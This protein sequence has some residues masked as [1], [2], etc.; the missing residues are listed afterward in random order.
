[1][2]PSWLFSRCGSRMC[3]NL[4]K[5]FLG[6]ADNNLIGKI[7]RVSR[8]QCNVYISQR[9]RRLQKIYLLYQQAYNDYA[10]LLFLY[11]VLR[12]IGLSRQA[13]LLG[14]CGFRWMDHGISEEEM[15]CQAD[16][17][18][19]VQNAVSST[20][21]NDV[22]VLPEYWEN[23]LD[24]AEVKM[25]KYPSREAGGLMEYK[26]YG[27]FSD[28]SAK[29]FFNIQMDNEYRKKWDEL[30]VKIEVVEED[31]KRKEQVLQ[32]VT[33]LPYPFAP[34]EYLCTRRTM[35][36]EDTK[37]VVISARA[38]S[39]AKCPPCKGYVRV[40]SY[41]SHMVFRPHKNYDEA[42]FDYLL[43]YC[44]D[45]QIVLPNRLASWVISSA[46]PDYVEKLHRACLNSRRSK[47]D[48]VADSHCVP[49]PYKLN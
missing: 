18:L 29:L 38:V 41:V 7:L 14:A 45:P 26:V 19:M 5:R 40:N 25:W 28:I 12:H 10:R 3:R 27:T 48:I 1:M 46:I 9:L 44:D 15:K 24:E 43:T 23:V 32:W 31:Q 30:V 39:H 33:R 4:K 49:V 34:R 20:S 11:P 42:G 16:E 13:L 22:N 47:S 21:G 17:L 37:T 6:T 8:T 35:S 2:A 36:D